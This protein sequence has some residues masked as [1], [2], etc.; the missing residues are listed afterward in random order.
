M[1][2]LY[3]SSCL[4]EEA[5]EGEGLLRGLSGEEPTALGPVWAEDPM[6]STQPC[7]EGATVALH[8]WKGLRPQTDGGQNVL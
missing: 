6:E 7:A 8:E 3:D 4:P 5:L 2:R 1:L